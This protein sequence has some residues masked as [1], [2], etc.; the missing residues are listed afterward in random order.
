MR[1]RWSRSGRWRRRRWR[2]RRRRL[3]R[4]RWIKSGRW[5]RRRWRRRR[6]SWRRRRLRRRRWIKSGRGRRDEEEGQKQCRKSWEPR[7]GRCGQGLCTC[8]RTLHLR[9]VR[10]ATIWHRGRNGEGRKGVTGSGRGRE[11]TSPRRTGVMERRA[12]ELL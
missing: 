9:E 1:R 5:R 10:A 6:W 2:W 12:R 11:E 3:R 7:A 4:R 8:V